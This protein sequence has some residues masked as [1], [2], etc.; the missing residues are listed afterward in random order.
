[1]P[2]QDENPENFIQRLIERADEGDAGAE[3]RI[4]ELT[5][6]VRGAEDQP[7]VSDVLGWI[8]RSVEHGLEVG[9]TTGQVLSH[10]SG[11]RDELLIQSAA[12][13]AFQVAQESQ[14]DTPQTEAEQQDGS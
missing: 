6:E 7:T 9:L 8:T 1:M 5:E 10:L 2:G 14:A 11:L 12:R 13:F 3:E 4:E